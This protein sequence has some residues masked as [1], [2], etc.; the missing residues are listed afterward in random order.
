VGGLSLD[1]ATFYNRYSDLIGYVPTD[2]RPANPPLDLIFPRE[3]RNAMDGETY[4]AEVSVHWKVSDRW[5]LSGSYSFIQTQIDNHGGVDPGDAGTIEDSTPQHQ[6][7]VHSYANLTRDIEL[8]A[9]L[10]FVDEIGTHPSVGR[11]EVPAYGRVDVNVAWRPRKD[12]ELT[13]GVQNLLE[14]SHPEFIPEAREHHSE[15]ERMFYAQLV[16]KF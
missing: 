7:Q 10:Y 4:G 8:N 16:W 13:V 1:L 6:F 9:S 11:G 2:P 15:V 5:R 12:L 14:E 3:A